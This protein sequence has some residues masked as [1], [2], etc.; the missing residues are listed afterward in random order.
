[1]GHLQMM[2]AFRAAL[3]GFVFKDFATLAL[4]STKQYIKSL[5]GT[6]AATLGSEKTA[7]AVV[8]QVGPTIL[9]VWKTVAETTLATE[10]LEFA[11][12]ADISYMCSVPNVLR[13]A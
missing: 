3:R 9:Y 4:A 12:S 1:G 8:A 5:A 10:Q 13:L 7:E 11:N 6:P 2:A